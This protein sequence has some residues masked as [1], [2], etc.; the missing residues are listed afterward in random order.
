M[1]K[2]VKLIKNLL[3]AFVLITIGFALGKHYAAKTTVEINN[4][5]KIS[6]VRVYYLHANRRCDSCN[7]I[8]EMTEQLL[9]GKYSEEIADD[10]I[11]FSQVNFQENKTLAK[12]FDIRSSCV[13]VANIKDGKII[14]YQRLDKVWELFQKPADFNA[15]V[16]K[17]IQ[18]Y[19]KE[20]K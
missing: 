17:A 8:Q 9:Y 12:R 7:Q 2:S 16:N 4:I 1:K 3:L 5:E 20:K 11:E 15:Y 13:V 18:V 14:A 19:L 6:L 10:K